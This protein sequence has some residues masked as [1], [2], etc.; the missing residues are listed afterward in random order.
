MDWKSK[1]RE[2]FKSPEA[3]I[4]W[5]DDIHPDWREEPY[6]DPVAEW[7]A[8]EAFGPDKWGQMTLLQSEDIMDFLME[9]YIGKEMEI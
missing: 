6:R 1:I 2:S 8:M 5:L 7:L 4:K 9:F 3:A